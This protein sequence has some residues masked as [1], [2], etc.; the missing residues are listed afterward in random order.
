MHL[1]ELELSNK[2]NTEDKD[3][4]KISYKVEQ[5]GKVYINIDGVTKCIGHV[6]VGDNNV[7]YSKFEDE[8][9]IFRKTNSW[10][11]NYTILNNV[12][13]IHYETLSHD[14]TIPKHRA[15]EFGEFFHFQ[16]TTE[17][18]VYVPLHYWNIRHKGLE[19]FNPQEFKLRNAIGD[20]WFVK[21]KST[22]ESPLITNISKYLKQR[23]TEVTVYP[24]SDRV[25]RAFKLCSYEHTKV[26]ILGQS[27]YHDGMASGLAFGYLDGC[28]KQYEKSLEIIYKEVERS[29]Y[30][31][32]NLDY[33]YTLESWAN[34]GVLLLNSSL[35]SEKGKTLA[36]SATPANLNGIG[37]ERFTKIVLFELAMDPTPKV[38]MLWGNVAQ[39]QFKAV[40]AVWEAKSMF[41]S[42]PHL[43]LT[44]R[45]PAYDL[46]LKNQFGEIAPSYP[47]TFSGCDHF[48]Q[49]NKFLT[50]NNR[51]EIRW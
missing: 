2:L 29:I 36:H 15:F 28:K 18:K 44:A 4:K 17:L 33:D 32:L 8:R 42:F 27:P 34:Q 1:K 48:K 43:V 13:L 5:D 41:S 30:D 14:Y 24:S 19:S 7:L 26:I 10:S 39:D 6:L 9:N 37:W 16:D 20:S 47:E 31:G 22:L 40:K 12:D 35:T 46:R 51:K 21:L 23:R 3:G 38:F 45:H 50:E 25:F 49:A 11:I